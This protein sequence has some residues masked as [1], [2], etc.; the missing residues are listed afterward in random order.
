MQPISSLPADFFENVTFHTLDHRAG[1]FNVSTD[2]YFVFGYEDKFRG[3]KQAFDVDKPPFYLLHS[4]TFTIVKEVFAGLFSKKPDLLTVFY[5]EN[6]IWNAFIV[7]HSD[8][9]KYDQPNPRIN[10][11]AD[12]F[13]YNSETD[14]QFQHFPLIGG[15]NS[16]GFD[17]NPAFFYLIA[18]PFHKDSGS[19]LTLDNYRFTK[20]EEKWPFVEGDRD[21]ARA[22]L[23]LRVI[24][25]FREAESDFEQML[26]KMSL[27][28]IRSDEFAPVVLDLY[29]RNRNPQSIRNDDLLR[30]RVKRLYLDAKSFTRRRTSV[31]WT[32]F[33]HFIVQY[34]Q[35]YF[36][37]SLLLEGVEE[38]F[39]KKESYR[40]FD[41]IFQQFVTDPDRFQSYVDDQV[42]EWKRIE[43]LVLDMPSVTNL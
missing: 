1:K 32:E 9:V 41:R 28:Y 17:K 21:T 26:G 8:F 31:P 22:E 42:R 15:V 30:R 37:K 19:L 39:S 14:R 36:D 13:A 7:G 20:D 2:E 33:M 24:K 40:K 4:E 23:I 35:F 5:D 11:Q 12:L 29:N 6:K 10:Q 16:Y 43:K 18:T 27:K 38:L 34:N 25:K 3:T